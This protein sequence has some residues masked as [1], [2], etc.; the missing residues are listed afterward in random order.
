[1]RRRPPLDPLDAARVVAMLRA[2]EHYVEPSPELRPRVLEAARRARL[3]GEWRRAV[4]LGAAAT[5]VLTIAGGIGGGTLAERIGHASQR[6]LVA[7][8]LEADAG[9]TR[10]VGVDR[11]CWRLVDSFFAA[12]A[13][14]AA[15]FTGGGRSEDAAEPS[16]VSNDSAAQNAGGTG[17]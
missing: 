2:A 12:R 13:R 8:R 7:A 1:M 3:G 5:V 10:G 14:Q 6:G 11:L 9:E 15:A 17:S 16:G 4:G